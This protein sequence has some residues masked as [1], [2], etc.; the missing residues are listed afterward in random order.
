MMIKR[1]LKKTLL[2][3]PFLKKE[4][5]LHGGIKLQGFKSLSNAAAV[6][7]LSVPPQLIIPLKQH[8]G[9]AAKPIVNVGDLV[10]KG[11]IIAEPNGYISSPV[12]ASSSG[13][14]AAIEAR[15]IP[16]ASPIKETCIV[17]HTDRKDQW[18][19][20]VQS[21]PEPLAL[22]PEDLRQRI[23]DAGIAGLGGAVF[24]SAVKLKPTSD[25]T[26]LIINGVECEPY[27]T[28]D[29][30]LMRHHADAIIQGA[31]LLARI[32][33]PQKIIVAIE[34]NKPQA[35][36]SVTNA[37]NRL[38]AAGAAAANTIHAAQVPEIFPAGGEKQLIKVLTG[39]E[40]P[41]GSLPYELGIICINVGT[42]AA[43]YDALYKGQPLVSRIMTVTGE[44]LDAPGNY[45]VL[46]GTPIHYVL[47]NAGV[48]RQHNAEVIMGGPMMGVAIADHAAPVVKATNCLLIKNT[49]QIRQPPAS[50]PCIRCGRCATVCPITL[51]PQQLYWHARSKEFDKLP[52]YHIDDCIECGCCQVVCPAKLPLVHYFR[53]AKSELK[54]RERERKKADVSRLRNEARQVRS[55]KARI[56]QEERK[57]RRKAARKQVITPETN[58]DQSTPD[59][60]NASSLQGVAP[61]PQTHENTSMVKHEDQ[62]KTMAR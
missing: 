12:H 13:V 20:F 55:E 33:R 30:V 44:G 45:R 31:L 52:A 28:C 29:D 23:R 22:P 4:C 39:K 41:S 42:T 27:I 60:L 26:T 35:F 16:H 50:M 51:L 34:D 11:Q 1:I 15:P 7:I 24:P 48:A 56:E 10:Y 5:K 43:I 49:R 18:H 25:I 3:K 47:A 54:A 62:T 21:T 19:P 36:Q 46:L 17:I 6:Q 37:I 61:E 32:V 14:V 8:I 53:F 58:P 38:K 59:S 2:Q 9:E 57:A 40:V